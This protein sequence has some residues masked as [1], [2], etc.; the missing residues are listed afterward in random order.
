MPEERK[1][2]MRADAR[3]NREALLSAARTLFAAHGPNVPYSQIATEAGVGVATL[4]RHFPTPEDLLTGLIER[5]LEQITDICAL[6]LPGMQRDPHAAWLAFVN[7]L[8]ALEFGTLVPQLLDGRR[9]AELPAEV[10]TAREQIIDAAGALVD[11]AKEAGLVRADASSIAVLAGLGA[12]TRPLPSALDE[13]APGM[14]DW[15]VGVYVAGLRPSA[16]R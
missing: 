8:V 16:T 9:L 14:R 7:D 10:L 12:I 11:L 3:A 5:I 6:R 2:L 1:V 4:Y 15:L 13:I